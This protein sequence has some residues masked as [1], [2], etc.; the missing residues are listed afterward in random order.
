MEATLQQN[1]ARIFSGQSKK[2]DAVN[3]SI[4]SKKCPWKI[5]EMVAA[6]IK[7]NEVKLTRCLLLLNLRRKQDPDPDRFDERIIFVEQL[8]IIQNQEGERWIKALEWNLIM[9]SEE[10]FYEEV[11][12]QDLDRTMSAL[13]VILSISEIIISAQ[14]KL[15]N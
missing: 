1:F 10:N 8:I 15:V 3:T 14:K 13:G 2:I 7:D 11:D 6:V 4:K 5:I 12:E 9:N